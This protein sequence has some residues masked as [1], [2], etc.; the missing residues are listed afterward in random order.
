MQDGLSHAADVFG[1]LVLPLLYID[2]RD[3][4]L[5]ACLVSQL[6]VLLSQLF[7]LPD[8]FL[9]PL[10]L[11]FFP[12]VQEVLQLAGSF[13]FALVLLFV[14][15]LLSEGISTLFYL[16]SSWVFSSS[17]RMRRVMSSS[18]KSLNSL[19]AFSLA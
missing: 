2:V 11:F 15:L 14:L 13:S 17:S 3:H 16:S 9:S 4:L 12:L 8:V 6:P 5:P 1:T 7:L 10:P 19:S 18:S